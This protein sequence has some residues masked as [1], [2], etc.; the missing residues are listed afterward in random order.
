M[1][2]GGYALEILARSLG[3]SVVRGERITIEPDRALLSGAVGPV[4]L[5]RLQERGRPAH[6]DRLIVTMD[7]NAPEVESQVPRSRTL[8]R[9]LADRYGV[10][11]LLDVNLGIGAQAAVESALV[12]PGQ[13][14]VGCGRCLGVTGGIG[15]LP[16]RLEKESLVQALLTG[17]LTLEVPPV[18]RVELG[19]R[20]PRYVGPLDLAFAVADALGPSLRGRLIEIHGSSREWSMDLRMG[21]CG[22]LLEMGAASAAMAPSGSVVRF[23]KDRG[24]PVEESETGA[25]ADAYETSVSIDLRGVG[26]R[27]AKDYAGPSHSLPARDGEPIQGVF[28]GSCYGG[29]YEDLSIVA[30]VLKRQGRVHAD[31]RL[32]VSPATLET[33]RA[34]LAAGFYETFLSAGAMV[35]VPGAGP[36]SAGG[37]AMFGEGERIVSTAEYHRLLSP[38]QGV[39][40]VVLMSPAAAAVAAAEGRLTDPAPF[41]V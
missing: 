36:G 19:G 9:D 33:A 23:Y 15:A 14:V 32:A 18:V 38:G 3:R 17:A 27:M 4:I 6:P 40:E 25:D 13:L 10:Q 11:H 5:Q 26:A 29:R 30:E 41:L 24:V 22:V 39:P 35:V 2:R 34:A 16:L 21:L 1:S 37:G 8:C 7:F 20:P 28:V 12:L 31:V